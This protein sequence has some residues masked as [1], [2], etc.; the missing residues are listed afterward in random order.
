MVSRESPGRN[1]SPPSSHAANTYGTPVRATEV[2]ERPAEREREVLGRL[3]QGRS[4]A[5]MAEGLFISEKAVAKH[6]GNIF[7][8]LGLP[9]SDTDNRRV[10]AV[11]AYLDR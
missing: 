10:L 3:A 9:P 6:I 8:K 7:T 4:N 5:G 11:L 1:R 2:H